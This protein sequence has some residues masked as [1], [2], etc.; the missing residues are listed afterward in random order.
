MNTVLSV[1]AW[2]FPLVF[3][4]VLHEIA[5]GMAALYFGDTTARDM[6]RLSLNPLRHVDSIGTVLFPLVLILTKAPFVFGWAKPVPVDFSRLRHPKKNMVWV[7]LAGPAMNLFQALC[8]FGV[9]AGYQNGLHA[10]M[11]ALAQHF[12]VN[13]IMLNLSVMTFN[14]IPVLPMDGGRILTGLLPMPWA[15]KFSKT[16]RYG[17]AVIAFLLILLPVLGNYIGRDFDVISN[18]LAFSVRRLMLFFASLFGLM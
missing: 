9:L 2:A 18:F 13:L 5:H 12:W 16:E 1:A 7:A 14:L 10:E 8:A 6:K 11:S 17:F 3:A 4:V 15:I